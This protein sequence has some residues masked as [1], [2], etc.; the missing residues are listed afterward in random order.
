MN[1]HILNHQKFK[2]LSLYGRYITNA[3]IE[4]VIEKLLKS[5]T[6]KAEIIGK[7]VDDLPIHALKFGNGKTKVLIWSQMHGN[8]STTTKAV[9]DV[10]NT[11]VNDANHLITKNVTLLVIPILNPDGA[12]AY[13]RL[14]ANTIDLNRD[15]VNLSQPESKVLQNIYNSFKPDLCLNMH[16]QRTIF[17]A[18]L[19]NKSAT[20]SFLAPAQDAHLS[21]TDN[22]K[23]AMQLIATMHDKLQKLIPNQIGRYDDA[24]NIN[25]VGDRFQSYNCPTIL[26]E[27]GHIDSDYSRESSRLYIYVALMSLFEALCDEKS[28]ALDYKNYFKIP[29]NE[30]CF[31]DIIIRNALDTNFNSID[32]AIQYEETLYDNAIYFKPNVVKLEKL[33][34]FFGHR[35]INA[36][37]MQVFNLNGEVLKIDDIVDSITINS[38]EISMK[39]NI[40]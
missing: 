15:A 17:S 22:R 35:E 18:G 38:I 40:L 21:I 36:K 3:S 1:L 29:E 5:N 28:N 14:N 20:V 9:F 10:L 37:Q 31:Y 39:P 7:S 30:K 34:N 11:L 13:T 4:P 6:I 27:A 19:A 2:V 8:E 16:G 23:Y 26:F 25:C 24:F 32:I 33:P 12:K